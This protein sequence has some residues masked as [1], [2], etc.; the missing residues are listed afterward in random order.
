MVQAFRRPENTEASARLKLHGLE[1][2]ARYK[3]TNLDH[4]ADLVM[5]GRELMDSGL[6]IEMKAQPDSAI[7]T[8][9]REGK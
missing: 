6:P 3:V 7:V 9:K 8:Y 5:T 4:P 2:G 1:A